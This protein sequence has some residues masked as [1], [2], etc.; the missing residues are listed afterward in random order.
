MYIIGFI[1]TVLFLAY[2]ILIFKKDKKS[3]FI[4]ILFIGIILNVSL[5]LITSI[6]TYWISDFMMY[7]Q[8][9]FF[10]VL[11]LIIYKY[12]LN[13]AIILLIIP[14]LFL[15]NLL[16]FLFWK[17]CWNEPVLWDDLWV[18]IPCKCNW[19]EF[20]SLIWP[21]TCIWNIN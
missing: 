6:F 12:K 16:A 21:H 5:Y 8:I 17:P 19:I 10:V 20:M 11:S 13:K 18:Y 4:L 2:I 9:L 1:L 15:W 14:L 7:L 3:M